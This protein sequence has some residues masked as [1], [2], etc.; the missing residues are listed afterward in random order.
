MYLAWSSNVRSSLLKLLLQR[1]M[2]TFLSQTPSG[3]IPPQD[4]CHLLILSVCRP[5]RS[6]ALPLL[7]YLSLHHSAH[8]F[9]SLTQFHS[10]LVGGLL[11]SILVPRRDELSVSQLVLFFL[12]PL[13]IN[14]LMHHPQLPNSLYLSYE[15]LFDHESVSPADVAAVT[16]PNITKGLK[17][18]N[19][20]LSVTLH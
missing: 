11:C 14:Q 13:C 17:L 18:A 2:E 6:S 7:L 1:V 8:I 19:A 9:C 12:L 20:W 5:S 15:K 3:R 4:L 10:A 16:R